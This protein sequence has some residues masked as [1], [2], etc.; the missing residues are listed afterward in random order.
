MPSKGFTPQA[1]AAALAVLEEAMRNE[2]DGRQFYLQAAEKSVSAQSKATFTTLA[3]DE[4]Q[5][6]RILQKE[7]DALQGS[8]KWVAASKVIGPQERRAE[9][10]FP[11]DKKAAARTAQA[12]K[13]DLEALE[14]AM[15]IEERA[16][17]LYSKAGQETDDPHARALYK[18]LANQENGHYQLIQRAHQY[19]TSP[20]QWYEEEEKPIFDGG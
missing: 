6:L 14:F 19:L 11:P 20:G 18:Y 15:G 8:G 1:S 10:L 12:V 4:E 16:F 17:K 5:H 2:V 7:L 13:S 3:A 9:P